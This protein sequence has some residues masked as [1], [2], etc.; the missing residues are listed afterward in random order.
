M[1]NRNQQLVFFCVVLKINMNPPPQISN[2]F[3]L[4]SI[5]NLVNICE[6]AASDLS[7]HRDKLNLVLNDL[8]SVEFKY[9]QSLDVL[10][11]SVFFFIVEHLFN[12]N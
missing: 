12:S 4:R 10:K 3:L 2:D 9:V 1:S 11:V 6:N 5:D 8:N 7:R